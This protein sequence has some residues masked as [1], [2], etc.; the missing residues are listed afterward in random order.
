MNVQI[1]GLFNTGTNLVASIIKNL[2]KCTIHSEG[3]TLFW[4]HSFVTPQFIKEQLIY[5]KNMGV[6]SANQTYFIIVI[7]HID[8]W[9]DSIKKK[10]YT[11]S[12]NDDDNNR[13]CVLKPPRN[14]KNIHYFLPNKDYTFDSLVECWNEFYTSAI[15]SLPYN[16]TIIVRY[17]DLILQPHYVIKSLSSKLTLKDAYLKNTNLI[18]KTLYTIFNTPSKKTGNPRYGE[19]AKEYYTQK[20]KEYSNDLIIS[21][22][23]L[24]FYT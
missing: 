11:L 3:N 22:I 9:I 23:L 6:N 17:E 8:S 16:R 19:G 14:I 15:R 13:K 4:K 2:Y 5:S 24:D 20:I 1:I 18:N 10:P 12:I 7:K 21:T